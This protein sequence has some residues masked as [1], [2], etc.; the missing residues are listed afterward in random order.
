MSSKSLVWLFASTRVLCEVNNSLHCE[1]GVLFPGIVTVTLLFRQAL[2]QPE[3]SKLARRNTF[4]HY[5]FCLWIV[6]VESYNMCSVTPVTLEK[7]RSWSDR[8]LQQWGR[9]LLASNNWSALCE[10]NLKDI[11]IVDWLTFE[12][13]TYKP[14]FLK[15]NWKIQGF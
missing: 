13:N 9:F 4:I 2:I 6:Y 12:I 15:H 11:K 14:E 7:S 3:L 1:Q 10:I 8:K 5:V